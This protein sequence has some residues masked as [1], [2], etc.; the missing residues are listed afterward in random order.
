MRCTIRPARTGADLLFIP[1]DYHLLCFQDQMTV[2][3]PLFSTMKPHWQASPR[4]IPSTIQFSPFNPQR[5]VSWRTL[6]RVTISLAIPA[7]YIHGCGYTAS[8]PLHRACLSASPP[9]HSSGG[10]WVKY[11]PVLHS[12]SYLSRSR[13]PKRHTACPL[14]DAVPL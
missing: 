3:Y 13:N 14:R 5:F 11:Y 7:L 2:T 9:H 4:R 8:I 6:T 12:I 10:R 1:A